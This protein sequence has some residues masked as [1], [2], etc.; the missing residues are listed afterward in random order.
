M[1][2]DTFQES[3]PKGVRIR[4]ERRFQLWV[5]CH[6]IAPSSGVNPRT[7]SLEVGRLG[8]CDP[9]WR[10]DSPHGLKVGC[11]TDSVSLGAQMDRPPSTGI[12][13][14]VMKDWVAKKYAA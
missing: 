4:G 8:G 7:F 10:H 2:G 14:P 11:A 1:E 13:T 9:S 12:Q 6:C 3:H 5:C